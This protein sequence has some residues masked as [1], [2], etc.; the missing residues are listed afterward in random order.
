MSKIVLPKV[1]YDLILEYFWSHKT[2]VLRKRCL[3]E[4]E[5]SRCFTEIQA[6]HQIYYSISLNIDVEEEKLQ[7]NLNE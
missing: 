1:I 4:L 3:S 2:F 7:E 6:F 5:F